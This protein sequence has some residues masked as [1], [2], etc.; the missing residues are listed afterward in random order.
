[1]AICLNG[2]LN[3]FRRCSKN[4]HLKYPKI[5]PY[6]ISYIR[7]ATNT[8]KWS[9][10]AENN[11]TS[12]P[13]RLH[14]HPN[15]RTKFHPEKLFGMEYER[16]IEDVR[17]LLQSKAENDPRE[18]LVLVD[19]IQ[20]FGLNSYFQEEI[21]TILQQFYK[22][23]NDRIYGFYNLHDVSLLFRLLRQHGYYISADVFNN[24]KGKDGKFRERLSL[25]IG[26]L[27]E[28]YEAAQLSFEGEY[29]L[30]EAANFSSKI[31]RQRVAADQV[32]S[33]WSQTI[34]NKLG[35]PYHKTIPRFTEKDFFQDFQW[36]KTL[37]ELA[38]MDLHKGRSVYQEEL[39][40]ISEWWKELGLAKSLKLARNQPVKWY[41]WSM[42]GLI[43]DISLSMQRV[44][45]TKSMAFVYLI[46]DI[47]DLYG[48]VDDLRIFTEAVNKWDYTAIDML[49]DYMKMCYRAL[50]DTTNGI[51]NKVTRYGV[52]RNFSKYM[53]C[54]CSW[55]Q[56]VEWASL[57]EAFLVEAKWLASGNLP[58][59]DLYLE[60]ANVT[61]GA[62]VVLVHLFF[63]LGLGGGTIHLNDIS[64]I[65]S[66]VATI[67]R[68][69]DDLGSA[70]DENQDGKDGSYIE[71]YTKDNKGLSVVEVRQHVIDM[72]ENEWKILNKE[73]F[74]VNQST[75]L[76]F[77]RASLNLAR[78]VSVMYNYDGNQ[79]LPV[80]EEYVKFMLF[81]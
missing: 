52:L 25:D 61:S 77:K 4:T 57:C 11:L 78:M 6:F 10:S 23:T 54:Y 74:C 26:G 79:R 2:P 24:F 56:I 72:I 38:I 8:R 39:R 76:S 69:W 20:R 44:E 16:K 43:D 63:L 64:Q 30:D 31:L 73:C 75:T 32:V 55:A 22:T 19:S 9:I 60:N 14:Q 71:C 5:E 13:S 47:F 17:H 48:E 29:I 66:S 35:H 18:S 21:G 1:M 53:K 59:A 65:I 51:A 80:L 42:A 7:A 34:T 70:K 33:N 27:M 12:D 45:L 3:V 40:Q 62:H 41:T 36:E 67:L 81:N 49:P 68:L 28:L 50:L 58:T 46:D 15:R 37:R